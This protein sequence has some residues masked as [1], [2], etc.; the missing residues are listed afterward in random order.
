MIPLLLIIGLLAVAVVA[1]G[2]SQGSGAGA[3]GGKAAASPSASGITHDMATWPAGDTIWDV[4][5]AIARAEGAN[6]ANSAPDRYNNP[7][8]LSRGDEHGQSVAGYVVLP[9]GEDLINFADKPGGWQALY[10]KIANAVNGNSNRYNADMT[11]SEIAVQ[12][13][14]DAGTWALNVGKF[15]GVDPD[16]TTLGDYVSGGTQA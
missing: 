4:C 14:G 1:Y 11:F 16:T 2:Q 3:D 15:L 12:W 9:D 10:L 6:V 7:G 5:R 8:D 13:A